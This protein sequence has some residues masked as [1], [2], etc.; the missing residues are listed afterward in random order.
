MKTGEQLTVDILLNSPSMERVTLFYK[1]AL[2]RLGIGVTTRVVDSSQYINRVRSRD[3]D[4]IYNGWA[5]SLSPGN[6]QLEYWGSQAAERE[7]SQNFAGIS[8]PGIDALI[9]KVI[10]AK[11]RDELVA[12][13]R[14]LD[15]DLLAHYYVVPTYTRR[16][17]PIA[18][19]NTIK[20]PE[21]LP[22]YAIGFPT[23]WWSASAEK[24]KS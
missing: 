6:E 4:M 14:A 12:A 1:R 8:D 5:E 16:K 9:R 21:S 22:K 3:Y 15:R 19:W 20:R 10:F 17:L 7:G 24:S 23:I 13:T 11:D 2:D 18:Y